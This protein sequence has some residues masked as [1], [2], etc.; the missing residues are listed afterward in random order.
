MPLSAALD[1]QHEFFR[2]TSG[3]W[4][5]DEESRLR[6]RYRVFDVHEL[7]VIA[8]K[9]VCAEKCVDMVKRAE[10]GF[11]KVFR[12]VMDNG[13]AVIA[14][15]SMPNTGSPRWTTASEVAIMDFNADFWDGVSSLVERDGWTSHETYDDA[16]ELFSQ[17]RQEGLRQLEGEERAKF[18][19]ETRWADKAARQ[20]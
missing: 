17:L 5:W 8:A 15:I 13:S 20:D 10:G 16:V 4:L 14:R 18:D 3:R 9:S 19:R 1:A 7:Q 11:N 12:L 6:E 2:Y